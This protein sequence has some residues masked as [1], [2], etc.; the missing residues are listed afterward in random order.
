MGELDLLLGDFVEFLRADVRSFDV[1]LAMGV[2]YHMADP[3][4]LIALT[5]ERSSRLVVWTHYYD[6]HFISECAP[7][8]RKHFGE[9]TEVITRGFRHMQH[10]FSYGAG[11]RLAGFYGGNAA[12][13]SWLSRDEL[14]GALEHFGWRAITIGPEVTNDPRGPSLTLTAV[15]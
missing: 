14:L 10:R 7:T 8:W 11:K 5:A 4:E 2:L 3:V 9:S 13:A 1:C 12:Y 15:R 6:E